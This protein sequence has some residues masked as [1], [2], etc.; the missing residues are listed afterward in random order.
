M[1]AER[2]QLVVEW[3]DTH[4]EY[5]AAT[6]VHELFE[7]QV[8]RTPAATAVEFDGKVW[9]YYALNE[10]ANRIAHRL[11]AS[12]V[13]PDVPVGILVER[14]A[15][16]IAGLFGIL[17]AGGAYV[18][19]DENYP[20]ERIQHILRVADAPVVI[21]QS[22]LVDNL[23]GYAGRVIC[24]DVEQAALELESPENP[25]PCTPPENLAYVMFTSGST[26]QPKGIAVPHSAL[27]HFV[28]AATQTY[29]LTSADRVLQFASICFDTSIEE[30]FPCLTLGA[31]LVVR[32]R[33]MLDSL[34][35]FWKRTSE[36]G[37][38]FLSLPTAFWHELVASV[39][40]HVSLIPPHLRLIVIGGEKARADRL[41]VWR[42]YVGQRI[43]ML[44]TYGPTESTV[45]ATACDIT[46]PIHG[47]IPIGRPILNVRAYLLDEL[48]QPVPRGVTGEIYLGGPGIA[49]G[50][51]NDPVRTEAA[52][53]PDHFVPGGR[54]YRTG[55]LGKYR[56]DGNIEFMGRVDSQVKIRGFRIELEE[57]ETVLGQHPDV[58][59]AVVMA[60]SDGSGDLSL[61]AYVTADADSLLS[62]QSLRKFLTTR[63]PH[64]MVPSSFVRME[65]FPTTPGG[66]VDRHKLRNLSIE[67]LATDDGSTSVDENLNEVETHVKRLWEEVLHGRCIRAD[68]DFFELG[69]HSLLAIRLLSDVKRE[70]TYG[71]SLAEMLK[72]PTVRSMAALLRQKEQGNEVWS[73]IVPLQTQGDKLP[74]FCAPVGGG[75]AFYYRTLASH[76]G[77]DQPLYTFE[78]IGMNGTDE[79]HNSV[80][81]MAAYYIRHMRKIQPAGP[82]SICGLSFGGIVA[83][84][85]ARQITE[86]SDKVACLV[87]FDCRAPGDSLGLDRREV[88]SL[89][90]AMYRVSYGT[91]FHLENLSVYSSSGERWRYL[92]ARASLL[93]KRIRDQV[94]GKSW[95]LSRE[96][97]ILMEL[98][99]IYQKVRAADGRARANYVPENYSGHLL[100]LKA[101][102]QKPDF[103]LQPMLGWDRIAPNAQVIETPGSHFSLLEEPCVRVTV[104]HVKQALESTRNLA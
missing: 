30:I 64:Y 75:S 88:D 6:S 99:E 100:L 81:D 35:H 18:P 72:T 50:Y 5:P 84:E 86:S 77:T 95:R 39:S 97:P 49:R 48:R 22:A 61:A 68:D 76:I 70:F 9:T 93:R 20:A 87:L 53:V 8:Q 60:N 31:T 101:H 54:L 73:P 44:N 2:N 40:E 65:V 41:N 66:K 38:T 23:D 3:N 63:L 69:G 12:G 79:P 80:E 32:T 29:G 58:N 96:N 92:K 10:Q 57:I 33:E 55:D 59:D 24:L 11:K 85:M 34:A 1:D 28:R 83:Y 67:S 21:T 98:P 104:S 4:T 52:F 91:R 37:I 43:Q 19:L 102:L 27:L 103:A 89:H 17:K 47:E 90:R 25:A 46:A 94:R 45:V 51:I 13:G 36:W 82:Y 62:D 74:L 71:I 7:S 15:D 16:L 14:S 26:G 56:A 78:P 42:Q